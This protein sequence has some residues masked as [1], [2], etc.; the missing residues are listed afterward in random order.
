MKNYLLSLTMLFFAGGLYAQVVPDMRLIDAWGDETVS[1]YVQNAP[2]TINY[3]NYYLENSF[4]IEDFPQDK[5]NGYYDLPNLELKEQFG[6][7]T[8]DFSTADL[9]ELNIL[10]FNIKRSQISRVTYRLGN[11]HKVITFYS[12][13]EL[14][15]EFNK[16][17]H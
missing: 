17:N 1:H 15:D 6:S 3:Y 8:H 16:T 5:G 9:K 4:Y 10:K 13:K 14:M 11:T 2:N 7:E 12:G